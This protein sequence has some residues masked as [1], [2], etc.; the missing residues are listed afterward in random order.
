MVASYILRGIFSR[1]TS[2]FLA[3]KKINKRRR[4]FLS[5]KTVFID[6]KVIFEL[7]NSP[8]IIIVDMARKTK[9]ISGSFEQ[10]EDSD[11]IWHRGIK[12]D[13]RDMLPPIAQLS[14][15]YRPRRCSEFLISRLA[16][17]AQNDRKTSNTLSL[18][19]F[20]PMANWILCRSQYLCVQSFLL[21]SQ[22]IR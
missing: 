17:S 13:S 7:S 15:V 18:F 21:F 5:W 12:V 14:E 6:G 4:I 10:V 1:S 22:K 11:P 2:S 20:F 9:R 16:P 8:T 3:Q 19:F